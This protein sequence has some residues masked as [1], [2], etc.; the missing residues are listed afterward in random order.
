MKRSILSLRKIKKEKMGNLILNQFSLEILSGE[1]INL[2]GLEGSGKEELYAILSGKEFIDSGDVWFNGKQYKIGKES[3]PV[4]RVN[5]IFLIGNYDLIIPDLTVAEN[6]YIIEKINYF[7]FSVSKKKMEQQTKKIFDQF[8]VKIDPRKKAK[9]LTP[10]ER[11][12]LRFTRA[13]VKRAKLIVVDDILDDYS[14]DK[15]HQILEILNLFKK[16]GISILWINNY[17]DS[18]TE[19]ADKIVVIRNG[20]N[21][22]LFYKEDYEKEKIKRSLTT[23]KQYLENYEGVTSVRKEN[24]ISIQN[25]K[26]NYFNVLSF[27]CKKGEILGIY[28]IQ[29]KF[30]RELKKIL[31][32]KKKYQ[33]KFIIEDEE[34]KTDAEY[35]LLKSKIAVVDGNAYQLSIFPDLSLQENLEISA[36]QKTA[37]GKYFINRRVQKYVNRMG[38]ELFE[39]NVTYKSM[40]EISRRDAMRVVYYRLGFAKPKILFCFQP[41][42]RLD[43]I[44][45]KQLCEIL[46]KFSSQGTGMILSSASVSDLI[47]LCDRILVVEKNRIYQEVER[48]SFLKV[49]Q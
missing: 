49:F 43:P 37:K 17:P 35:K 41:F 15:I 34:I 26:N 7:Q 14:L 42:L 2:I 23:G 25:I 30:S 44:S 1:I 33:G 3:L 28:D 9:N 8:N 24:A 48:A 22:M 6:I 21:G 32:G 11:C 20:K 27:E 12:I 46:L 19:A 47:L 36:Y 18:I 16:E 10:Y 29:N 4:E 5:G 31:L 45:R 40:R 39:N 13:Y 38:E